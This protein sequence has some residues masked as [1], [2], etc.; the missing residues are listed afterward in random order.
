LRVIFRH[1]LHEPAGEVRYT[2]NENL[3]SNINSFIILQLHALLRTDKIIPLIL[4]ACLRR[5]NIYLELITQENFIVELSD[6][7]KI[8]LKY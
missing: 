8:R 7:Y 1:E 5:N 3:S 2:N 6:N 4:Y